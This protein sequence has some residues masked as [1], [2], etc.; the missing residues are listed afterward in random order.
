MLALRVYSAARMMHYLIC[1]VRRSSSNIRDRDRR[2][3]HTSAICTWRR[4]SGESL[5]PASMRSTISWSISVVFFC[6]SGTASCTRDTLPLS[7]AVNVPVWLLVLLTVRSDL[8]SDLDA[9]FLG[10][11]TLDRLLESRMTLASELRVAPMNPCLETAVSGVL[12]RAFSRLN[13]PRILRLALTFVANASL[14]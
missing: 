4:R 14:F 10:R 7:G 12:T 13:K 9:V 2:A 3:S 6:F 11:W 1:T 8:I 5:G